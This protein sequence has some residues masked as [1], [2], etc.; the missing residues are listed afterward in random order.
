MGTWLWQ[1]RVKPFLIGLDVALNG[2]I[3]LAVGGGAYQ[4]V[5]CRI[6]LSIQDGGWASRVPWPAWLR[7]HFL[8]AVFVAVV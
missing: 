3:S 5:S 1:G 7:A 4:T 6:G 8:D 2:L